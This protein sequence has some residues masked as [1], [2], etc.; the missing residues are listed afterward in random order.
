ME[1]LNILKDVK[2]VNGYV[3]IQEG[4]DQL[5]NLSF[6]SNLETIYGRYLW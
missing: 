2:V 4:P 1:D 3:N 5:G 6:L